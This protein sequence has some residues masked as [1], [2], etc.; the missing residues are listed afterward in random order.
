[1]TGSPGSIAG[2][3]AEPGESAESRQS[4]AGLPGERWHGTQVS[5]F[6][7]PMAEGG[8]ALIL[9]PSN[10]RSTSATVAVGAAGPKLSKK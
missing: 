1:M 3:S 10:V 6:Y 9:N 5:P 8:A 7:A 2:R 4:R